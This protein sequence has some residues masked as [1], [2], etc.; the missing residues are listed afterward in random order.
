MNKV[1]KVLTEIS[2]TLEEKKE[3]SSIFADI[4][5]LKTRL[6][7]LTYTLDDMKIIS[8][9]CSLHLDY[10]DKCNKC[11]KCNTCNNCNKLKKLPPKKNNTKILCGTGHKAAKG[12][13]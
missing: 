11:N 13:R 2:V 8:K 3:E 9:N 7:K 4:G 6:H 10:I 12:L 5:N 1:V